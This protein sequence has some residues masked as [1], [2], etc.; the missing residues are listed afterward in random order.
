MSANVSALTAASMM[1]VAVAL[2]FA[3]FESG[4]LLETE[5]VSDTMYPAGVPEKAFTTSEKLAV[6]AFRRVGVVQ[7]TTRPAPTAG[8]MQVQP[9]GGTGMETTVQPAGIGAI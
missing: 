5:L 2:L 6:A 7:M 1:V 3:G 4:V 8:R 9:G